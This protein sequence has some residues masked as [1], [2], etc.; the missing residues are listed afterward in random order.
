MLGFDIDFNGSYTTQDIIEKSI[1]EERIILTTRK[2]LKRAKSVTH[3]ILMPPDT[4]RKQIKYVLQYLD[5]K[6]PP[7]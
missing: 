6:P 2:K 5:V 4:T 1:Q 3:C 7:P